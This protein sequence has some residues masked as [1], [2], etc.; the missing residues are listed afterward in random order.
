MASSSYAQRKFRFDR[1]ESNKKNLHAKKSANVITF[2]IS[3]LRYSFNDFFLFDMHRVNYYFL[4]S[5][6]FIASVNIYILLFIFLIQIKVY[7]YVY[8]IIFPQ[9]LKCYFFYSSSWERLN[10][11]TKY[12][13]IYWYM[14]R[15]DLLDE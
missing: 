12:V 11:Y 8:S 7:C 15:K 10:T 13:W 3:V 9:K 1:R 5:L 2:C 4:S 6:H 14:K